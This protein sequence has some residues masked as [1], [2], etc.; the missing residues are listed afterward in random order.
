MHIPWRIFGKGLRDRAPRRSYRH[1]FRQTVF[2]PYLEQS[3][4]RLFLAA[5]MAAERARS[6]AHA[7]K[8]I[9]R[10][11]AYVEAF[12]AAHSDRYAIG[13]S[14]EQVRALLRDTDKIVILHSIEGGHLLL[15]NPEDAAFWA[16]QGVV[17]M[18]LIHLR[19]DELGSAG[20][21]PGAIGPIVNRRGAKRRRYGERRGLTF[22]GKQAIVELDAAG[23]LVDLSHMTQTSIDD[24]LEVT[25]ANGIA[26]VITHGKLA[27]IRDTE[28]A[29]RDDQVIELYRQGGMFSLGLA[30]AKLDPIHPADPSR[31]IP[32][33]VCRGTL[34][35][36]RA[37][38]EAVVAL[39]GAHTEELFGTTGPLT[40]A[41]RAR[42][43]VGWSSDWNGWLS[44]SK[45]VYGAGRCRR[46]ADL[47][48]GLPALDIDTRGLAHPGMLPQHWERLRRDGMDLEPMQRSAE[49]FL[50]LWEQARD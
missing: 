1:Q 13:R 36:F 34:E 42:L 11:F 14:P 22:R 32:A 21:L 27:A 18:T 4:V 50:Q 25:G 15:N 37:H 39:L 48:D 3:G 43:A 12:V 19:D 17:L 46:R 38:H 41:Q 5:A 30:G 2:A 9:L 23:I 29:Q 45:P 47:P 10:Q 49:R 28:L 16:E 33:D 20:I 24:A 6:P 7:R 40:P 26:P 44:H 31:A 35:M 8:L